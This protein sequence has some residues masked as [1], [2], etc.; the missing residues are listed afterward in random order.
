L[1]EYP[2][3]PGEIKILVNMFASCKNIDNAF[4]NSD[5]TINALYVR[6]FGRK[7]KFWKLLPT[8]A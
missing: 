3:P 7:T 6:K 2:N 1:E 4:F 8:P 5:E